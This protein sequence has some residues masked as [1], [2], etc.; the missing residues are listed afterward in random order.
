MAGRSQSP[1][2]RPQKLSSIGLPAVNELVA[3]VV[4]AAYQ[5]D[6][7]LRTTLQTDPKKVF[8]DMGITMREEITMRSV[9]NTADTVHVVLPCYDSFDE[10]FASLTDR[11]LKS[12]AGG[13]IIGGA[14]ACIGLVLGTIG[15]VVLGGG[16][17][18]AAAGYVGCITVGAI[19]VGIATS[20]TMAAVGV[21]IA[22]GLGAFDGG[23]GS[24][25][26]VNISLAG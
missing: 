18:A 13:D 2:V 19:V 15:G 8:S 24:D 14:I 9:V 4:A 12:I 5:R 3:S 20:T 16:S 23:G 1:A 22:A 25:S 17:L 7:D 10:V 11:Q 6:A 26:S 21:G